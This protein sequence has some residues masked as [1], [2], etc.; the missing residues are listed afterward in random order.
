[1][2]ELGGGLLLIVGLYTQPVSALIALQFLVIIL[3]VKL[4]KGLVGGYEF[5]L[6]IF[7]AAAALM[8]VGAGG[9]SIDDSFRIIY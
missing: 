5:D 4:S 9:V 6:L 8:T 3:K 7:A 2:A 1:M